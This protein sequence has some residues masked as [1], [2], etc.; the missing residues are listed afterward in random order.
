MKDGLKLSPGNLLIALLSL[1]IL[2]IL[3]KLVYSAFVKCC[4]Y[5]ASINIKIFSLPVLVLYSA[6][7]WSIIMTIS[8]DIMKYVSI[9]P[10]IILII[11]ISM[12]VIP[13][14]LTIIRHGILYGSGLT[15]FRIVVAFFGGALIAESAALIMLSLLVGL[16][17]IESWVDGSYIMVTLNGEIMALR[18]TGDNDMYFIDQ[19]GRTYI[20]FSENSFSCIDTG[21]IYW[22]YR[23][24]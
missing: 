10:T 11:S 2:I 3:L 4:Q 1:I 7:S 16:F 22:I 24:E 9:N 18:R 17:M 14:V 23:N 8:G 5:A 20:R 6:S 19:N 12:I 21:E 13:T 15:M